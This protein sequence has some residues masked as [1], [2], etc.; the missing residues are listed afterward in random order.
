VVKFVGMKNGG[1][2]WVGAPETIIEEVANFNFKDRRSYL[3]GLYNASSST[4][5]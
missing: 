3:V 5:T 2:L 1:C 4:S